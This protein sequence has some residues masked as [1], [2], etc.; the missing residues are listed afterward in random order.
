MFREG[1]ELLKVIGSKERA[2]TSTQVPG[3]LVQFWHH[4]A[5]PETQR[6]WNCKECEGP[7][8]PHPITH[9]GKWEACPTSYDGSRE[10]VMTQ[11]TRKQR[12]Y[13]RVFLIHLKPPKKLCSE[14][15]CQNEN[16]NI[17][18]QKEKLPSEKQKRQRQLTYQQIPAMPENK[19]NGLLKL[20]TKQLLVY[21]S[22]QKNHP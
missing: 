17:P 7:S 2:Q 5:E 14:H 18:N 8:R 3:L 22:T 9:D 21:N 1:T 4:P 16:L 19:R 13:S 6:S 15:Q 10:A 12:C 11:Q 20:W